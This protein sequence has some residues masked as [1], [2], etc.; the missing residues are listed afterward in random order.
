MGVEEV[1]DVGKRLFA[2][3][4]GS[5]LIVDGFHCVVEQ[6][7]VV[8]ARLHSAYRGGQFDLGE[9]WRS[10]RVGGCAPVSEACVLITFPCH[11]SG[12]SRG[13]VMPN[14]RRIPPGSSARPS[15]PAARSGS[16]SGPRGAAA[17]N[18][19]TASSLGKSS[20]ASSGSRERIPNT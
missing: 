13:P 17:T 12:P 3:A 19:R 10:E 7:A 9:R 2:C 1:G 16:S 15:I 18:R 4:R 20:G 11:V 5:E 6:G 8:L 14:G